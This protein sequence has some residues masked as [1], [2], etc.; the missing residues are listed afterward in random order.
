MPGS[1]PVPVPLKR[2]GWW[3]YGLAIAV[4][5]LLLLL[6]LLLF[7]FGAG[8]SGT[9][10]GGSGQGGE[11]ASGTG[12]TDGQAV[13]ESTGEGP[14]MDETTELGEDTRSET[15]KSPAP[16][17]A[18][19]VGETKTGEVIE[20]PVVD[21]TSEPS[22]AIAIDELIRRLRAEPE[23][24]TDPQTSN[25]RRN[26]Q[27][28]GDALV[29]GDATVN[30]FGA[31]GKGSKFVFVFDRSG[32]M[33]GRPLETVKRELI[34]SLEPLKSNHSFNIIS[35]DDQYEMWKDRLISATQGNKADA[36]KFIEA[37]NARG[38]TQPRES[39]LIAINQ[40]PEIIFFMTDGVFTLDLD[41]IIR[42]RRGVIIN[43]V[44]FSNDAPL[45]VLQELARRTGGDFMLIPVRGLS[46]AL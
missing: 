27:A 39:L 26:S 44:Q 23:E 19:I 10:P 33:S 42:S 17:T 4:I 11:A 22:R 16:P 18:T 14:A 24:D 5:I 7:S 13:M 6:L 2:D 15:S 25:E 46:D 29:K 41:E 34:Q 9:G 40:R 21:A 8:S 45:A 12:G 37:T 30:F 32:S 20:P 43:V 31:T 38:G 36:I 1:R 35:Y 3:K 28:G